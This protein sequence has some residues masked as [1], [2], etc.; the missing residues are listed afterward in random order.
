ML[1][2]HRRLYMFFC[3]CSQTQ[4][5]SKHYEISM[6]ESGIKEQVGC[7]DNWINLG[8]R[9]LNISTNIIRHGNKFKINGIVT[10]AVTDEPITHFKLYLVSKNV[11]KYIIIDELN[12]FYPDSNEYFE[13]NFKWDFPSEYPHIVLDAAGYQ[14][15]A[16]IIKPC[17]LK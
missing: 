2:H 7:F 3:A 10:D 9:P 12:V 4:K 8:E 11:S 16:Y 1:N 14:G 5:Y 6:L 13:C 15:A 17:E